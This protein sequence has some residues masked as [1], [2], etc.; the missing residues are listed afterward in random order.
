[1][2][3]LVVNPSSVAWV[4]NGQMMASMTTSSCYQ[5]PQSLYIAFQV[6]GSPL[7]LVIT[8]EGTIV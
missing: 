3:Q 7:I 4:L 2:F 1:M 8:E 6:R 5:G